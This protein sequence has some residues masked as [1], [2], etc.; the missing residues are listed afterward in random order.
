MVKVRQTDRAFG[1]T[2]ATVFVVVFAVAAFFWEIFLWWAIAVAGLFLLLALLAPGVLLPLNRLW[3]VIASR[4]GVASNYI[5]LGLFFFLI[6][7]PVG[8]VMRL[9]GWDPMG[10]R[11]AREGSY[12]TGIGRHTDRETVKDMF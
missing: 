9:F 7:T 2:F 1:F 11:L 4:L 5:V 6:V 10:R 12:W 8:A 3:G